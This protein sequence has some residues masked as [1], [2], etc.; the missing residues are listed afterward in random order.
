MSANKFKV[1]DVVKCVDTGTLSNLTLGKDYVLLDVIND[2]GV[3]VTKCSC[4]NAFNN[5]TN[6]K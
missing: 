2:C 5:I 1:G 6:F 3:K 4:I